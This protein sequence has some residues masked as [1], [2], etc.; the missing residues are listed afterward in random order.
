VSGNTVIEPGDS[1]VVFCH[2]VDMK[3]IEK[4]FN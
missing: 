1:V 3:K 4:M 2:N